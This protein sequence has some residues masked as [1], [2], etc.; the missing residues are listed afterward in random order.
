MA[1]AVE[2]QAAIG[3]A[4]NNPVCVANG[5]AAKGTAVKAAVAREVEREA[6]QAAAAAKGTA[7]KAAAVGEVEREAVQTAAAK[8]VTAKTA[9]TAPAGA[10]TK[11]AAAVKSG[12][13]APAAKAAAAAGPAK[14]AAVGA[15]GAAGATGV[16]VA[17][18]PVSAAMAGI[19]SLP[20]R[21]S[22][23]GWDW[24]WGHGGPFCWGSPVW[25]APYRC[26]KYTKNAVPY[27]PTSRPLRKGKD[28]ERTSWKF[29]C[30][31]R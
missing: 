10:A 16:T 25:L 12:T 27:H 3:T 22:P 14:A 29:E 4:A 18:G 5:A 30:G 24:G 13:T 26:M 2:T 21:A 17:S 1:V 8:G 9:A 23:W 11:A 6:A 31:R 19:R 28:H 20:V 7:V 15:A